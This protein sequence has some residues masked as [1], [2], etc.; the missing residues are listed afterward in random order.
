MVP[1][2]DG[3]LNAK[4]FTGGKKVLSQL[5]TDFAKDVGQRHGLERGIEGSQAK[6]QTIKEFYAQVNQ[7][8]KEVQLSAQSVEPRV[9][10]GRPHGQDARSRRSGRATRA[11]PTVSQRQCSRPMPR[12]SKA[13]Q[14][15][16]QARRAAE[17][18]R[19]AETL[20]GDKK[21]L[22]QAL[23]GHQKRF[24]VLTE[25]EQVDPLAVQQLMREAKERLTVAKV[26]KEFVRRVNELPK[27]A[28]SAAGA[29]LTLAKR[30]VAA[31]DAVGGRIDKVDWERVET[32][33]IAESAQ[34][35]R[36]EPAE[37]YAAMMKHSPA[38]ADAGINPERGAAVRLLVEHL[39]GK[40]VD[41]DK[42]KVQDRGLSR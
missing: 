6:H 39:A 38:S 33:A 24:E 12:S 40:A 16:L 26:R 19:T 9:I 23:Q 42:V 2:K 32:Q 17:M 27:L 4:H 7:P 18:A 20:A 37:V 36:Q 31:L 8:I 13:K 22:E 3:K 21:R 41:L 34:Q 10:E 29:V 5:Q 14:G 1:L 11:W 15:D 28:R 35:H 30:G 25:L